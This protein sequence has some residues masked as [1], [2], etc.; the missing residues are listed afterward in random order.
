M[1]DSTLDNMLVANIALVEARLAE[2]A[3]AELLSTE[4]VMCQAELDAS[5]ELARVC[6]QLKAGLRGIRGGLRQGASRTESYT[7]QMRSLVRQCERLHEAA[8]YDQPARRLLKIHE[9]T[10]QL[11][12]LG[13]LVLGTASPTLT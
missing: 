1:T 8:L 12:S 2:Q 4:G 7:N 13:A 6:V 5:I 10:I 3:R 9:R 11:L